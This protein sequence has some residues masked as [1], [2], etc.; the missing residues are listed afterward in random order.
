MNGLPVERGKPEAKLLWNPKEENM[1]ERVELEKKVY[2]F[3][4]WDSPCEKDYFIL[5][6]DRVRKLARITFNRP[7]KLNAFTDVKVIIMRGAGRSFTSGHDMSEIGM[8]YGFGE[9]DRSKWNQRR[10][11]VIDSNRFF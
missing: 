10:K 4:D 9:E 3:F 7:E 5:E 6:K 11:I 8:Y 2:S 1:W